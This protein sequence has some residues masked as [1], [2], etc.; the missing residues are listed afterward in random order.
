MSLQTGILIFPDV[1]QLDLTAPYEVFALHPGMRVHLLWKNCNPL[2]SSTGLGLVPTMAFS[3]CPPLDVLCIPGGK[4]VNPLLQDAEVLEFIRIQAARAK[5]VTSVCTGAL[6]LGAAGLLKGRRA[7]THW[8]AH[9][10]LE[11][12]GAIPARA[13]GARRQ[14][15]HGGRCHGRHRLR[16]DSP[17]GACR[18][19]PS[20]SRS[21]QP[22]VFT[23]AAL[24][25]RHS[26]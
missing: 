20:G 3:A 15:V 2:R 7:T 11:K 13:R 16:A 22:G 21:A 1:Q 23:R 26:G 25:R 19:S 4:G 9:D 12:F 17:G 24:P 8:A 6:L 18:A 14:S 5:Y 10:L